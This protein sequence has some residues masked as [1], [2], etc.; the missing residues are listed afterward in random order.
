MGSE[1]Y[2]HV[3]IPF[4]QDTCDIQQSGEEITPKANDSKA[5]LRVKSTFL[6]QEQTQMDIV[7]LINKIHIFD[8]D[9]SENLI[10]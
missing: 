6:D 7:P 5:V 10:E 2:L 8:I 4:R 9:T 3:K 1:A